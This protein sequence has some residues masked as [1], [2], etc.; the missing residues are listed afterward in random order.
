MGQLGAHG[1]DPN[2]Q[3]A[4][5]NRLR[6]GGACTQIDEFS[7]ISSSDSLGARVEPT[8]LATVLLLTSNVE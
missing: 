8:S 4:C 5:K 2:S 7:R 1:F 6:F 3:P